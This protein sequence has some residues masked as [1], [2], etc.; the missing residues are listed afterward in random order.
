MRLVICTACLLLAAVLLNSCGGGGTSAPSETTVPGESAA[1]ETTTAAESVYK[2]P[3]KDYG[4]KQFRILLRS[5]SWTPKDVYVEEAT[6]EAFNDAVFQRNS[7]IAE[8]YNVSI[9][10]EVPDAATGN[11]LNTLIQSFV[12]AGDNAYDLTMIRISDCAILA[13][14]GIYN[15]LLRCAPLD[16]QQDCWEYDL[17]MD[18]TVAGRLYYAT[19]LATNAANALNICFFN[20]DIAKAYNLEDMYALVRAGKFTMDTMYKSACSVA[21]DLNGDGE[22]T[23]DDQFG[24]SAQKVVSRMFWI[25]S[26]EKFTEKDKDG[27]P[28][29]SLGEGQ[30]AFDVFDKLSSIAA[31]NKNLYLGDTA[32]IKEIW[33]GGRA[34]FYYASLDNAQVM[35]DYDFDFGILPMP[36]YNDAQEEYWCYLNAHNPCGSS[37]P[38][39]ADKDGSALMLQV[40]AAYSEQEVIPAYYDVCLTGKSLRDAES[41]EMLDIIFKHWRGDLGDAY[42]WGSI[43]GKLT[44]AINAGTGLASVL[45]SNKDAVAAAIQKTTEAYKSFG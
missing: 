4:G 28:Y 43:A 9:Y 35:R 31:D 44:D 2:P 6:G 29:L 38:V 18:T 13:Q 24:I 7:R 15:D 8:D 33:F 41:E 32:P 17:L 40:R 5:T 45:A 30:R 20:K 27:I 37:I 12:T 19:G 10:G 39:T 34:L 11:P 36:K 14:A 23:I 1:S 42:A 21:K 22:M 16:F 25:A 26:G 3:V